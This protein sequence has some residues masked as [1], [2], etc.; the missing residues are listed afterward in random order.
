MLLQRTQPAIPADYSNFMLFASDVAVL[1]TLALWTASLMTRPRSVRAG[2]LAIIIPLIGLTIAGCASSIAS[3]DRALSVYHAIRLLALLWFYLYIVNELRSIEWLLI[4]VGILVF[5]Q[6]VVALGQLA[7][8]HS[9]GLQSVGELYLDPAQ[10]GVSVVAVNGIRLLR[11]Y[12]LTDHPNVLGGC[13]AFGLLLVIHGYLEGFSRRVSLIVFVPG[14]VA[15]ALSFSRSAW[16]AFG[17]GTSVLILMELAQKRRARLRPWLWLG[18][19]GLVGLVP[20]MLLLPRFFGVRLNAGGS[21]TTPS[22][23]QQS[24]G[25]RLLLA[26]SAAAMIAQHPALGV[27]LGASPLA[28]QAYEPRWSLGFEPP[29]AALLE[30]AVETGLP[31]ALCYVA[32]ITSP[33]LLYFTRRKHLASTSNA[34]LALALL[35]ALL[36]AGMFDYYPWLLSPGRLWQWLAWGLCAAA[37]TGNTSHAAAVSKSPSE[38]ANWIS[39]VNTTA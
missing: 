39:N 36:V 9:L 37:L 31:G 27:G 24:I 34:A 6:S 7:E 12:G 2:P 21:F 17:M 28:F 5:L 38:L 26:R 15:L 35:V 25:E 30:A 23:E 20:I 13:L 8:Q 14:I 1:L 10:H 4:P 18:I 22:A 16:L 32:L 29:H 3:Y 11:A 33:F 19:A